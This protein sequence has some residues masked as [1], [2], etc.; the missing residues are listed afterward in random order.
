MPGP[1]RGRPS[2]RSAVTLRCTWREPPQIVTDRDHMDCACSGRRSTAG[3]TS[4]ERGVLAEHVVVDLPEVLERL[5]PDQLG[6]RRLEPQVAA[7]LDLGE[8]VHGVQPQALQVGE[9]AGQPVAQHR[10]ACRGRAASRQADDRVVLA[11]E[12]GVLADARRAALEGQQQHR[13]AP[14]VADARRGT[15]VAGTRASVKNTSP[16]SLA[17]LICLSG[18]ASTPGWCMSMSSI[19]MPRCRSRA[20]IRADQGEDLVAVHGVGGPHLLAVDHEV[21]AVAD[22]AAGERREVG[23]RAGLGEALAP[24]HLVAQHRPDDLLLLRVGA[25]RHDRGREEGEAER[26]DGARRVGQHHLLV[27]DRLHARACRRGRRTRR[28]TGCPRTRPRPC[29]APSRG[30]GGSSR[31]RAATPRTPAAA[32]PPACC[33]RARSAARGGTPPR[34]PCS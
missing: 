17:P 8:H 30:A 15:S 26:V 18:R 28:A 10:V 24:D 14:A 3:R 4:V 23:A 7:L 12:L 1:Y 9:H 6:H 32:T 11:A 21:V 2:T 20:R 13:G 22:A 29:R 33:P 31:R 19:E 34:P 25:D 16:N 27:V 5:R